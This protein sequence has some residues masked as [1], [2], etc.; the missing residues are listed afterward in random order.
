MINNYYQNNEEKLSKKARKRYRNFSEEEKDKKRQYAREK[1]I[2]FSEEENENK[3]QY[4]RERYKNLFRMGFFT[5]I[6]RIVFQGEFFCYF[7]L[8]LKIDPSCPSC[9]FQ[10]PFHIFLK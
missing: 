1:Y 6:I 7:K 9:I 4:G 2:N 5:K 3:R 8:G 10:Y